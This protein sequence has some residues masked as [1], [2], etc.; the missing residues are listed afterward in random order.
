MS[1]TFLDSEELRELTGYKRPADQIRWLQTNGVPHF[2]NA[3]RRPV[4]SKDLLAAK[5]TARFAL[6]EVR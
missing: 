4:A 5:P 6:G 2:V 3:L 1:S